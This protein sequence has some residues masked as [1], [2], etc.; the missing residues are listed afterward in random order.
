MKPLSKQDVKVPADVPEAAKEN[1]I[2]NFLQ[3]T[4]GTGKLML[5]AGDQK[6]EPLNDDF[7]GKGIPADDN[8]PEHL[9]RIASKSVIGVFATQYGL[10]SHYG[11]DYPDINYVVKLNSKTG[12]VPTEQMEP[13]SRQ[14]WSIKQVLALK[15]AGLRIVGVGYTIYIGSEQESVMLSQAANLIA[16][17]HQ[18]GLLVVIWA[19]PRGKAVTA[20]KDPHLIAGATGTIACLGADF[21][22][23][24]YPKA[25]NKAEALKEAVLAAGRCKVICAGGGSTSA[26]KFYQ[27][28]HDQ[29]HIAGTQGNATGRNI[30]Q[31][32]LDEAIRFTNGISAI[33]LAEKDV[34]F[35][36]QVYEGKEKFTL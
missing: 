24:N 22:K 15:E 18:H 35:A 5:M 26:E 17:A 4:R 36:M 2:Q 31:R 11:R 27:D 19:Y 9:F 20:E 23:V 6:V 1:Y 10:I 3:A 21:V 12:I 34:T 13:V 16:E 29:L 32:T 7:Y 28:L 25:D 33:T 30:H 8:D 14:L